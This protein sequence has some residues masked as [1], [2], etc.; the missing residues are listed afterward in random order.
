MNP[1]HSSSSSLLSPL[2]KANPHSKQSIHPI[3]DIPFTRILSPAA[4][5]TQYRRRTEEE[6]TTVHW[7]QRKLLMSEIEFLLLAQQQQKERTNKKI[8]RMKEEKGEETTTTT[9][10]AVVYAGA[11]PGTHVRILADMFPSHTFILVDPAPFTVRPESGRIV[12][13]QA[14]FT[15]ELAHELRISLQQQYRV[16]LFISDVRS[17]DPD[18]HTE[19]VH[20]ERVKADMEAQARWHGILR[21]HRSMLKFRL[22]YAPGSTVYLDGDVHLPVWGPSSTTECRLVVGKDAGTRTYDHTEHEERMFHFNTV[23]RPALYPHTVRGGCG[24]DHCY[25]CTA[26]VGILRAYLRSARMDDSDASVAQLSALVSSSIS[27]ERTLAHKNPDRAQ[28]LEV[29]RKRQWGGSGGRPSYEKY[30]SNLG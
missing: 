27:S 17:C 14:M 24:I 16:V 12:I 23:T 8:R 28:K 29:I 18:I 15:D 2:L 19:Q 5:R 3:T 11:A 20:T 7:G 9:T 6:K 26:E 21:P 30:M 1:P 13:H 4:P 22:P 25:D 10:V